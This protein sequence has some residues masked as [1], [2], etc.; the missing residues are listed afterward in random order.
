MYG[1]DLSLPPRPVQNDATDGGVYGNSEVGLHMMIASAGM[2]PP[3]QDPNQLKVDFEYDV[4]EGTVD[5]LVLHQ[6]GFGEP[7]GQGIPPPLPD[8]D[9]FDYGDTPAPPNAVNYKGAPTP[10]GQS[11]MSPDGQEVYEDLDSPANGA[12]LV[13]SMQ[14]DLYEEIDLSTATRPPPVANRAPDFESG[15]GW[16]MAGAAGTSTDVDDL[17]RDLLDDE[18]DGDL[19]APPLAAGEFP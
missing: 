19:Q 18:A 17:V 11:Q 14:Q 5:G 2:A 8:D 10:L 15:F 3:V 9:E 4:S 16:D 1:I 6:F 7:L 13:V 12:P